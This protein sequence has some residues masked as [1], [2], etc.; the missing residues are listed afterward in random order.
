[1]P[2]FP[3][4]RKAAT[5]PAMSTPRQLRVFLSRTTAGLAAL[6][7][8]VAA[9]LTE[10]GFEIIHQPDFGLEWRRIRHMLMEKVR[11]ADAVLCLVGPAYGFA[12]RTTIPE[13]RHSDTGR[14]EYSYTQL[15]YLIARRLH[16]PVVTLLVPDA[17]CTFAR[18]E[19]RGTPDQQQLQADF[20]RDF[21]KKGEHVFHEFSSEADLLGAIRS[22]L[23]PIPEPLLPPPTPENIPFR[24]IGTIFTGRADTMHALRESLVSAGNS[25]NGASPRPAVQ[26]INGVGGVGKTRLTVEFAHTH[27]ADYTARLFVRGGSPGAL[28]E[29]LSSLAG[30][31]L[32]NL[33]EQ[34]EKETEVRIAAVLRWLAAHPGYLLVVDNVDTDDARDH[35]IEVL[36]RLP[37]GHVLITS[38]LHTWPGDILRTPLAVL[39]DTDSRDLLLKYRSSPKAPAPDT[40]AAD[41]LS[42]AHDLDGLALALEQAAA[43]LNVLAITIAEYHERWKTNAAR[44]REWH[45]PAQMGYPASVATTWLT[46][47]EQLAAASQALLNLLSWLAPDP[48]PRFLLKPLAEKK[49]QPD[50]LTGTDPYKALGELIHFSLANPAQNGSAFAVHR[51]IQQVTRE[52]QEPTDENQSDT[53]G[54][55]RPP[56]GFF[57]KLFGPKP[58][59]NGPRGTKAKALALPFALEWVNGEMPDETEDVRTWP[60]A[61]P[62]VPHA[63]TVGTF[64]ADRHIPDPTARLMNQVARLLQAK[65][66][67]DAAEVLYRRALA[68]GEASFGKD[69]P[70]VASYLSGLASLLCDTNRESEAE[71]LFRRAVSMTE[72]WFGPDNPKF[73]TALNNLAGLLCNT[74]RASEA[75]PLYRRALTIGEDSVGPEHPDIAVRLNNLAELLRA[76]NR[77]A[78]AE[79]LFRRALKIFEKSLGPEHPSVSKILNNLA[80]VLQ[81]TN[82]LAEAEPLM[83]RALAIDEKCYGPEHPDVARDLNNLGELLRATERLTDAEP[84]YRRALA[85]DEDCHGP[86]HPDVARDLN[87]LAMLLSATNRH[88]EAEPLYRRT[89]A[90]FEQSFGPDHPKLATCLNN[91]ATLLQHSNEPAEAEQLF[92][93]ALAIFEESYGPEHPNVATSLNN[94]SLLLSATNRLAEAEP[95]MKRALAIDEKSYGAEHPTVAIRIYNLTALLIANNKLAEA[96]MLVRPWLDTLFRFTFRRGNQHPYLGRLVEAYCS[97]LVKTGMPQDEARAFINERAKTIH[98]QIT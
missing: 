94:L 23:I 33:E 62:L 71:P 75:E 57:A 13:F 53:Q 30:L 85:I 24:S 59:T 52:R 21:I 42:L 58:T 50:P 39:S 74:N 4:A 96:E 6:A 1:M 34:D 54:M 41:A 88:A 44:V 48:I 56:R 76:S 12:P 14:E 55:A 36:A 18:P 51:L 66:K 90:I 26:V 83:R 3:P 47:F 63:N 25:G 38:R 31:F 81:A 19:D 5:L 49:L 11:E 45:D 32:L 78:E 80:Q 28:D 17:L 92:R 27:A 84:L 82:H 70:P 86:E 87:N 72:K 35:A 29:S 60:I 97:I 77:Q 65:A 9:V 68:I 40:D 73:A 67:Y 69:C 8:K 64:A 61:I 10:R 89:L 22:R 93:R 7:E 2:A 37:V 91:L 95:L 43:Y 98:D 20:I 79:P 16:K 15:E 46:S